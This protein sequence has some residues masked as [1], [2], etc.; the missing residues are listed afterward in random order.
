MLFQGSR[1]GHAQTMR[2]I[3]FRATINPGALLTD[4]RDENGRS[5]LQPVLDLGGVIN[6]VQCRANEN[7]LK[8]TLGSDSQRIY[9][10]NPK[11]AFDGWTLSIS[12][13]SG[14]EA[15][16]EGRE[17]Y[18]F[19]YNDS[20]MDGCI[21]DDNDG[22][23]G[24]LRVNPSQAEVKSDC[25]ECS[26]N[27]ISVG[28]L[29]EQSFGESDSITLLKASKSSDELGSWY[30]TGVEVNQSVPAGQE[31]DQYKLDLVLTAAAT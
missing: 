15:K 24:L 29:N 9:V 12:P 17:G 3:E 21:D 16:W 13:A 26:N 31:G 14:K 20:G 5:I 30:L 28:S 2:T 11:A 6:S 27:E 1:L 10:D 4:I 23:A 18:Y 19:D 25:L 22:H 7:S 8:G